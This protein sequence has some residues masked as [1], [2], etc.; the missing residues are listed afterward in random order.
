M[1]TTTIG[2]LLFCVTCS[3]LTLRQAL[4][5]I[6]SGSDDRAVGRAGEISRFQILP[7]VW[8]EYSSLPRYRDAGHAWAVAERILSDRSA[9]F[10]A[11]TGRQPT[12]REIYVLW[13]APGAFRRAGYHFV[14]LSNM[15]RG[16]AERFANLV[17]KEEH[18]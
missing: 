7:T 18:H 15:V 2:I 16:K 13:N 11:A 14:G 5:Q 10:A 9:Q 8:R 12:S 3:A 17:A 4:E 1:L 6:E